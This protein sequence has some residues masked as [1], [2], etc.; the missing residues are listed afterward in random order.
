MS[1]NLIFH[2]SGFNDLK[3]VNNSSF[4]IFDGILIFFKDVVAGFNNTF[5]LE[6]YIFSILSGANRMIDLKFENFILR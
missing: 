1:L 3:I 6:N 2:I 4:F 5:K